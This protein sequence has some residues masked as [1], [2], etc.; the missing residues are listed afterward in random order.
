V[1]QFLTGDAYG[2][3][4]NVPWTVDLWGAERHPV[5]VYV[6]IALLV[7]LLSLLWWWRQYA[8]PG[9]TFWRALL[10]YGLVELFFTTFRSNPDTW[11]LGI[12]EVQVYSLAAVL[13]AMFVLSYHAQQAEQANGNSQLASP[14]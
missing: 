5:Q 2:V 8:R 12:R 9:Q 7:G 1:G 4:G 10:I 13:V 6:A 14:E 3:P 11:M